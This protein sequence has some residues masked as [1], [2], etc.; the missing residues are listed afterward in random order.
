MSVPTTTELHRLLVEH[1]DLEELRT[2]AFDLGVDF[3]DLRGEGKAAKARELIAYL[4]RRNR[5]ANLVTAIKTSR[6]DIA[7]LLQIAET[8]PGTSASLESKELSPDLSSHPPVPRLAYLFVALLILD[9]I[10]GPILGWHWFGDKPNALSYIQATSGCLSLVLEIVLLFVALIVRRMTWHDVLHRLGISLSLQ[11]G[12]GVTTGI[13][14][15]LTI[16]SFRPL[17][18]QPTPTDT[19]TPTITP[20][21]TPTATSTPTLTPTPTVTP[22]LMPTPTSTATLT[23][24]PTPIPVTPIP[25]AL[26]TQRCEA[27]RFEKPGEGF[28]YPLAAC[29]IPRRP[30]AIKLSWDVSESGSYAGCII[31]LP[32]EFALVAQDNTYLVLWVLGG[33]GGEQFKIGLGSSDGAEWKETVPPASVAGHQV[34]IPLTRFAN[35]GVDL[36]RLDKLI[37]A[38]E[39]HLGASSRRG[40][41]CIDE[42]G[43]GSP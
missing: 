40:R 6:S 32:S 14:I 30:D 10:L 7:D 39:Y 37:I 17:A 27:G 21:D 43:F 18:P 35:R 22:T 24:T 26:I 4:E 33:Q 8:E 3:D 5:W 23:S 29:Y 19:P 1:F 11:I 25:M 2:L 42:I 41:I 28:L 34:S 9:V 20:T 13:L 15:L 12:I 36:A 38:F 31:D 16:L